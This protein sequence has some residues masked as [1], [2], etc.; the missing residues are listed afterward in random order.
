MRIGIRGMI[1]KG[2]EE[3]KTVRDSIEFEEF[4]REE[5]SLENE[6]NPNSYNRR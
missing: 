4:K 6:T 3:T 2:R 5:P 1:K